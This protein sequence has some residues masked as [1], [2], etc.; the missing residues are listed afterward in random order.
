MAF[1][2]LSATARASQGIIP[3]AQQH[4]VRTPLPQAS[5]WGWFQVAELKSSCLQ[6]HKSLRMARGYEGARNCH[7]PV[8]T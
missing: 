7:S 6:L 5:S 8:L 2:Q 3:P 1:E 4:L